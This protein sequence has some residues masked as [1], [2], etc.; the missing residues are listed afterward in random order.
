MGKKSSDSLA[1]K[2]VNDQHNFQIDIIRKLHKAGV[3]IVCG[4]DA[5]VLNTAPGFSIHQE[6]A[7]YQQAGMSNYEALKTATV[8]PTKVYDEYSS[9]GTIEAGKYA[10][11][12]LTFGNPLVDLSVLQNPQLVMIKGRVVDKSLMKEFK[13]KAYKRNNYVVTMIKMAKYILWGK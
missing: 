10:N 8:N 7:F 9:F 1:T 2:R 6:L 5:G 13:E 12:I 3:N 4:T 11:L